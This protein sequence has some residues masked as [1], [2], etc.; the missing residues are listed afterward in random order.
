MPP[1]PPPVSTLYHNWDQISWVLVWEGV[2]ARTLGMF[3]TAVVQA[4]LIYGLETWFM[5]PCIGK[6]LVVFHHQLVRRLTGFMPLWNLY[7]T[8][9]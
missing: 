6:T 3:Y 7:G 2:D 5:S 1:L 9:N 8:C 4:V